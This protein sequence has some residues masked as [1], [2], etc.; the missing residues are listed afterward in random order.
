MPPE[1]VSSSRHDDGTSH[2]VG[3]Y[4]H[5]T[6][7]RLTTDH[8]RPRSA[9][10]FGRVSSRSRA[11][12]RSRRHRLRPARLRPIA[13]CDTGSDDGRPRERPPCRRGH[14]HEPSGRGCPQLRFEPDHARR[15]APPRSLRRSRPLGATTPLGLPGGRSGRRPYNANVASSDAPADD[16]EQMY[17]RLLG[18][19]A[20]SRLPADVR[21]QRRAEGP[22][23]QTDMASELDAPFDFQ[24]VAVPALVGY[25]SETSTEHA[26][27]ARWLAETLPNARTRAFPG[28]GH[29]APRTHPEEY[30]AFVLSVLDLVDQGQRRVWTAIAGRLRLTRQCPAA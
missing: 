2:S 3:L 23:F 18:D 4:V 15:H 17:R 26:Y 12:P 7:P 13:R 19:D 6:V 11:P 14:L 25:G 1:T 24:D 30:A 9:G 29:F 20:W 5:T 28:T 10:P 21:D 8:P 27:G 22:A 16:V